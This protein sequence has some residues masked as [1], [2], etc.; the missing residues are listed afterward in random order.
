MKLIDKFNQSN[1]LLFISLY[2]KK[3]E[4]YSA[5]ATG[6]A[7][8]T[9]N[10]VSNLGKSAVVLADRRPDSPSIYR[11]NQSLVLRC[12]TKNSSRMWLEL[13]KTIRQFNHI[14]YI[15]LQYDSFMYGGIFTSGLILPFVALLRLL[16]YQPSVTLHSVVDDSLE[17]R[18]HVGLDDNLLGTIKGKFYNFIFHTFYRL[19][20][21]F[22]VKIIVLEKTLV[23]KLLVIAPHAQVVA[24][25]HGVDTTL[26]TQSR[27]SARQQ[28]KISKKD[29]V[30]IFFGYINW[31]KGADFFA[32]TFQNINRLL[33]R[34]I[35]F[36]IAGGISPTLK[37]KPYYQK[38]F[39]SIENTVSQSQSVSLTGYISQKDLSAYFAAT[40][41]VVFPYRHFMSASGVLSLV[42]S[43]QKPFI[44]SNKLSEMFS[45]ADFRQAL[46]QAKLKQ[47]D[48]TFNLTAKSCQNKTQKILK[49]GLLA[50]A[51]AMSHLM[52]HLRSYPQTSKIYYSTLVPASQA[53]INVL[54][55]RYAASSA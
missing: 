37:N 38:Y 54:P 24:I 17:L 51:Q 10:I 8:Y 53:A 34:R 13:F 11:E 49:N 20:S 44:I 9:K 29:L 42:F 30:V 39:N 36:I 3:G 46:R 4:T 28:L 26:Q 16:G 31:F 33:G 23:K 2:P 55:Y 48:L 7:S 19:L 25:P 21:L 1:T 32:S 14:K 5:G 12:F 22:A 40:D 43:Y 50:K 18:G 15:H 45:T 35:R 52:R 27:S 6:I 47:S 41:L